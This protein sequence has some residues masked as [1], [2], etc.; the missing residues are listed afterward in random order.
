M[1]HKGHVHITIDRFY[2]ELLLE[3]HIYKS[4]DPLTTFISNNR[5]SLGGR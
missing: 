2:K 5:P 3:G 4:S 1:D